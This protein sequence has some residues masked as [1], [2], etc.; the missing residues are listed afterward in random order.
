M[1]QMVTITIGT[2]YDV[3]NCKIEEERF[4]V[5]LTMTHSLLSDIFG[6][7]TIL[8][9]EGSWKNQRGQLIREKGITVKTAVDG[10]NTSLKDVLALGQ[11]LATVWN[12]ES[13]MVEYNGG[14]SFI[15]Q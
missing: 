8:E 10:M 7:C 5:N 13:V 6:G 11:N 4:Q 14:V 12:Q 2:G 15:G 3:N 1:M 9:S